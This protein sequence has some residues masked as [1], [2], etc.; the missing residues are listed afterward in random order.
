MFKNHKQAAVKQQK[1]NVKQPRVALNELVYVCLLSKLNGS[2]NMMRI[3]FDATDLPHH[4]TFHSSF[5]PLY[6][7]LFRGSPEVDLVSTVWRP[8]PSKLK[9]QETQIC[10]PKKPDF[11][12]FSQAK[13]NGQFSPEVC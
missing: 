12:Y 5:E 2:L 11:P 7:N 9:S 8:D 3:K 10:A 4:I 13:K 6:R 1:Q